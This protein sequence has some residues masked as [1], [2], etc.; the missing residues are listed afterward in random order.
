ML[1]GEPKCRGRVGRAAT[2]AGTVRN[3]LID[4]D[5]ETLVVAC[6]FTEQLERAR[7]Q[8]VATW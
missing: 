3:A 5:R 6:G 7:D 8:R 1:V 4:V 2:K